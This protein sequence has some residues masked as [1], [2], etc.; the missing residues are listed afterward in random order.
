MPA[1]SGLSGGGFDAVERIE[2]FAVKLPP[3]PEGLGAL[4]A[5]E[6]IILRTGAFWAV[7]GW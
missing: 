2:G 6:G 1:D 5:A 3:A 7:K 4:S